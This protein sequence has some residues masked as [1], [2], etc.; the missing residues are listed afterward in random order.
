[1]TASLQETSSPTSP[2]SPI[3]PHQNRSLTES[4]IDKKF[5]LNLSVLDEFQNRRTHRD[6]FDSRNFS[7]N[8]PTL[9]KIRKWFFL[10]KDLLIKLSY[11]Y[12]SILAF[13]LSSWFDLLTIKFYSNFFISLFPPPPVLSLFLLAVDCCWVF[14]FG[15]FLFWKYLIW[16]PES[17][18]FFSSL[19]T[20]IGLSDCSSS[21]S[22]SS[23]LPS[24][25]NIYF[26]LLY[27]YWRVIILRNYL[28]LVNCLL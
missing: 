11:H 8:P 2:I 13:F 7:K 9:P 1:M 23:L 26:C 22:S 17:S 15:L 3:S 4:Q 27:D 24:S 6:R 19:S 25:I 21:W 20:E 5:H 10:N 14:L 28:G 16:E 12:L 18:Y